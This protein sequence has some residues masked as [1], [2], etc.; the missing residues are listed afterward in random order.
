VQDGTP[1]TGRGMQIFQFV[2]I[3][4]V[5]RLSAVAWDDERSCA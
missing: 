4:A 5:W 1:V 3:A 2:R